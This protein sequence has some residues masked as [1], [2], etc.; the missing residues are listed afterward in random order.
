[1][2]LPDIAS[3]ISGDD[4]QTPTGPAGEPLMLAKLDAPQSPSS[5]VL[6][7]RLLDRVSAGVA[8]RLTLVCAPAGTGKTTLLLSWLSSGLAPGAV[9][10]VSLDR[11]D[12]KPGVFWSYLLTGLDRAGVS[13]AGVQRP[14][15]PHRLDPSFLAQLSAILYGRSDPVVVVLDDADVLGDSP[16]CAQL[17]LLARNAGGTLRL[18]ILTR[19]DS[20]V[21]MPRHRL[22]GTVTEVREAELAAS[23][24]EARAL[25]ERQGSP[26]PAETLDALMRRTR[27]WIA[28]IVLTGL[29]LRDRPGSAERPDALATVG[30]DID[31]YLDE[32][33]LRTQPPAV[34]R[35]LVWTSPAD[36]LPAGLAE[37]LTG[38]PSAARLLGDLA[39]R[40]AFVSHCDRHV[41]CY[42]YHPLLQELLRARLADES[43]GAAPQLH[44]RASAWFAAAGEPVEAAVHA[45]AAAEWRTAAQ[46]LVDGLAVP[47]LRMGPGSGR[48]TWL[49]ADLPA[50]TPGAEAAV[51][52]AA[53]ALARRDA[54]ACSAHLARGR[55]LAGRAS[56]ERAPAVALGI[57]VIASGLAAMTGDVD[58]ALAVARAVDALRTQQPGIERMPE[59]RTLVLCDVAHAL[60]QAGRLDVAAAL[61]AEAQAAVTPDCLHLRPISVGLLSLV[62][63]LQGRLH[64]V[65]ELA[66]PQRVP[67]AGPNA[68]VERPS[69]AAE[70]A[71]AWVAAERG[72]LEL[73]PR[74]LAAA[75]V[76][77]PHD[78]VVAAVVALV[79]AAVHRAEGDPAAALAV[80]D[81]ARGGRDGGSVPPW[82]DGRLIAAAAAIRTASGRPD[83]ASRCLV[84]VG[85]GHSP[86]VA[87]ELAWAR[88]ALGEAS[89]A[90][91][92]VSELLRQADLALD[93]RI[94]AWLLRAAEALERGDAPAARAA[95]DRALRAA[96][97]E[98]LRRPMLEAPTRLRGFLRHEGDLSVTHRWLTEVESAPPTPTLHPVRRHPSGRPALIEPLTEKEHEVLVHLA[99]LLSTEEIAQTM[100]VSV[101]TVRT[102]VRAIL[103]KLAASRRNEAIRR[104]RDLQVI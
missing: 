60:L 47:R 72:Q 103:R 10:W 70:A 40:N 56:P 71:L 2:S 8:G 46:I 37:E 93:L 41:D 3:A 100:F 20:A 11:G 24:D 83:L 58:A 66:A 9:V 95:A 16:V 28:G 27:G 45:I 79:R 62:E 85:A 92:A 6:R 104:A 30:T 26:L 53:I 82:L 50:D 25:L 38:Q 18:V 49:L 59:T 23:P 99:E 69:P 57:S 89:A 13:V 39:R 81:A 75:S 29:A 4:Q 31:E 32:E 102:H 74:H 97:P 14:D 65:A 51:V 73:V 86:E 17:D 87:L 12:R 94:G 1:M 96:A 7:P 101:N 78:P 98:R 88:L 48:L 22:A 77:D 43:P 34:R 67:A 52:R 68:P 64:R 5:T 90:G 55:E 80:L 19:D 35:F 63:A 36:H 33:V 54:A 91:T 21:P 44:R 15:H 84:E 42:R 76:A 61:L